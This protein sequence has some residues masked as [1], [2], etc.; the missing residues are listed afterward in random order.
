MDDYHTADGAACYESGGLPLGPPWTHLSK[1]NHTPPLKHTT[2]P[3]SF[4]Y[5]FPLRI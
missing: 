2:D 3:T 5:P 1:I 4:N